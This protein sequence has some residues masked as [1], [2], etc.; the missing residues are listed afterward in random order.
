MSGWGSRVCAAC[1]QDLERSEYSQN[2]WRKGIG[3]SRCQVCVQENFDSDDCNTTK[4]TNNS[5]RSDI[6]WGNV[7]G[8]G[9]FRYV[10]LGKYVGGQRTGQLCVAKWFKSREYDFDDFVHHDLRSVEVAARLINQWNQA[11]FIDKVIRLNVPEVWNGGPDG[12]FLCEPYIENF[13]KFNSNTGWTPHSN[14]SGDLVMQALSHYSYHISS[15]MY[16]LCDLQG[17]IYRDGAILTDPVI[18]SRHQEF[19]PTDLGP[20]GISTFFSNHSCNEF[21]R[22]N[23][24][25]PRD[26]RSYYKAYIGSTYVPSQQ[27]YDDDDDDDDDDD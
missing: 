25:Q 16:L 23:W 13:T 3:L 22:A 14:D 12:K 19:G 9:T 2:Q 6:D 26:S 10:A 17:G 20:A 27:Y 8:E 1:S 5:A 21:C 7:I 11:G 18:Q 15:G 4:R 24:T